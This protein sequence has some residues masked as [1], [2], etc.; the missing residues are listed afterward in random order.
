MKTGLKITFDDLAARI[1]PLFRSREEIQLGY[2]F[3]SFVHAPARVP[4][5]L[6][7]AILVDTLKFPVLDKK[8]P[9]GY[10]AELTTEIMHHLKF[11]RIDLT[12]LHRATPVLAYQVIHTGRLIFSRSEDIRNHF[13]ITALKRHVDTKYLRRIKQYYLEKRIA[14]GLS[15]YDQQGNY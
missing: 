8:A 5:D 1:I 12:L 9:Y 7:L 11:N 14:G 10:Q 4:E 2:L 3:G 6:D 15:A 13:E